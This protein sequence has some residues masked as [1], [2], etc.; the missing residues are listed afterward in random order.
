MFHWLPPGIDHWADFGYLLGDT[1][2]LNEH[3]RKGKGKLYTI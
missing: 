3:E 2:G 1:E